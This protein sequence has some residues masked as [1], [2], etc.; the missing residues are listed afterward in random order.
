MNMSIARF[1][2]YCS[3]NGVYIPDEGEEEYIRCMMYEVEKVKQ[4]L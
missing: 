2:S 3:E 4:Y 1:K